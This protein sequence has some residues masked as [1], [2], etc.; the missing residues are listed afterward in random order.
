MRD[1]HSRYTTL[2]KASP[3]TDRDT[4]T[5]D[6]VRRDR[7]DK[8]GRVTLRLHGRLRHIA[9]GRA[10]ARTRILMLVH[11]LNVTVINATTGELL[12]ELTI[13]TDRDY[14]PLGTKKPPNPKVQ[15]FPM[16]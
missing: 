11:D 16:S 6:R 9:I 2:P 8:S 13:D 1:T 12:R 5:H 7:I 3:T 15:G 4:D 10:H 14:Q